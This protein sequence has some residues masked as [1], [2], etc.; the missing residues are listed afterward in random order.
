MVQASAKSWTLGAFLH[1]LSHGTQM[2][3]LI[4]P[5]EE[6][7]FVCSSKQEIRVFDEPT[8]KLLIPFEQIELSLGDL[9]V[10]LQK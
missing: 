1:C 9:L 4:D 3:W 8:A 2:G 5:A 10:W 7:I 6:T